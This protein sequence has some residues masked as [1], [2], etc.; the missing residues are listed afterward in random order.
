MIFFNGPLQSSVVTHVAPFSQLPPWKCASRISYD[1]STLPQ[2]APNE[3]LDA[4]MRC[5]RCCID[6]MFRILNNDSEAVLRGITKQR[7]L[8]CVSRRVR[9]LEKSIWTRGTLPAPSPSLG[10]YYERPPFCPVLTCLRP[11]LVTSG[12]TPFSSS[13]A[14]TPLVATLFDYQTRVHFWFTSSIIEK[15]L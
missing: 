1:T 9:T 6:N 12:A 5:R 4:I 7:T 11:T 2:C 10:R 8:E 13:S 14:E 3:G 15:F